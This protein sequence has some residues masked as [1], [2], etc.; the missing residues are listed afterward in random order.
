MATQETGD[1]RPKVL[2]VDDDL[3]S[4]ILAALLLEKAGYSPT[5]VPTVERALAR[6]DAEGTDLV[7]TDLQSHR[8]ERTRPLLALRER[9]SRT[10]V[11][12]LT[13]SDDERADRPRVSARRDDRP[14]EAVLD[15]VAA[16]G[17]RSGARHHARCRLT[18]P[19]ASERLPSAKSLWAL[20]FTGTWHF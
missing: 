11:I 14:A 7:L 19:A 8:R 15:G 5:A 4:R 9:R 20:G 12:V 2:V 18:R 10:P 13:A 6:I 17:R 1:H 16:R 3:A